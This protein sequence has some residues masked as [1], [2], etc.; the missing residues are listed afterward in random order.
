MYQ[1][2]EGTTRG[3][4]EYGRNQNGCIVILHVVELCLDVQRVVR[5]FKWSQNQTIAAIARAIVDEL[6]AFELF[7]LKSY[8]IFLVP[9]GN[10]LI[11]VKLNGLQL[12][13][14]LSVCLQ[15]TLLEAACNWCH[16]SQQKHSGS[17]SDNMLV[18]SARLMIVGLQIITQFLF[19]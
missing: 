17:C 3:A 14:S 2:P 18:K 15:I 8:G 7:K 9:P 1:H 11:W 6:E 19:T 10:P 5:P 12:S 16:S 4:R 13:Q